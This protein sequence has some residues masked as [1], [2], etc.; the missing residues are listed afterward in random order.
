MPEHGTSV[1][2]PG[3]G[4]AGAQFD[5]FGP[6]KQQPEEDTLAPMMSGVLTDAE[7]PNC[8]SLGSGG[9]GGGG[10][11][12]RSFGGSGGAAAMSGVTIGDGAIGP[13]SPELL[14]QQQQQQELLSYQ[15]QQQQHSALLALQQQQQQAAAAAAASQQAFSQ[16]GGLP[17]SSPHMDVAWGS[18][19]QS[20]ADG[21]GPG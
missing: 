4:G 8:F 3:A 13:A 15:Q 10:H 7:Q 17:V 20:V 6:V 11:R 5:G 14:Q 21:F 16:L 1:G 18:R 19:G 2:W 9:G 12:R